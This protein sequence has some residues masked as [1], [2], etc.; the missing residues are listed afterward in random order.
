MIRISVLKASIDNNK[1]SGLNLPTITIIDEQGRVYLGDA[2]EINGP[3]NIISAM[4]EEPSVWVETDG[5]TVLRYKGLEV[6]AR[7]ADAL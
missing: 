2:V 4:E 7:S 6:Y 3:S 1:R 5:P